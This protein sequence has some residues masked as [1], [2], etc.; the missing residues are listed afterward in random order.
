MYHLGKQK[1]TS[2][3]NDDTLRPIAMK[4]YMILHSIILQKPSKTSKAKEHSICLERRL[5][6]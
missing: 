2:I 1:N 5:F 3:L 6:P 4:T